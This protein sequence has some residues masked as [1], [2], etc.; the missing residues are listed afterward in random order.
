MKSQQKK[1]LTAL[2][3]IAFSVLTLWGIERKNLFKGEA[4]TSLISRDGQLLFLYKKEGQ[5]LQLA[6]RSFSNKSWGVKEILPS[7]QAHF[8]VL[9]KDPHEQVWVLWEQGNELCLGKLKGNE[10]FL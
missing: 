9:K 8:P 10:L 5:G 6:S 1:W 2:F 3:G 4:P 7:P